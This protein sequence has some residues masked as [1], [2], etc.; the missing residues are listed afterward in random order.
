M[1]GTSYDKLEDAFEILAPLDS[2]SNHGPM[3]AEAICALGRGEEAVGWTE[4]YIKRSKFM[5]PRPKPSQRIDNEPW[6]LALGRYDRFPDWSEFFVEQIQEK[7]WQELLDEW[8]TRL[9]AGFAAVALH[10]P[11]RT[12]HAA[13]ALTERDTPLRR[14]EFANGLAHWAAGFQTLPVADHLPASR[15]RP[16]QMIRTLEVIPPDRRP[17]PASLVQAL[18]DLDDSPFSIYWARVE[19]VG[20]SEAFLSDL[21]ETLAASYVSNA[22]D[23]LSVLGFV[24]AVTGPSSLRM[25]A[26]YLS[27]QTMTTITASAW[28]AAAGMYVRF[29]G[30]LPSHDF[31]TMGFDPQHLID[32][33]IA[34]DDEHAIKFTEA[35][36]REHDLNPKPAY[37]AAAPRAVEFLAKARARN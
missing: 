2:I 14:R 6:Q 37:L 25:I 26:P 19:V 20:S 35:C 22:S 4:R 9:A 24:H 32:R 31:A 29:G 8:V 13:R 3:G 7:P 30:N 21:T 33:A 17:A 18:K 5:T 28:E 11:I 15:E 12:C 27:P 10:G 23:F 36:L 1:A 34:S 16:S